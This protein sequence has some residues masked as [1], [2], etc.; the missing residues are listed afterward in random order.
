MTLFIEKMKSIYDFIIIDSP[1][2]I[3]VTD[4]EILF[5]IADG[6]ILV[7]KAGKTPP[8]AFYRTCEKLMHID[9]HN[10]LGVVFNNFS[11]KS[12]YGYYYN[13]YYY[14]TRPDE[15]V[16]TNGVSHTNKINDK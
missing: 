2:F 6:T 3:S 15:K 5:R 14:Y 7:L 16:N 10:F 12:A 8:D 9:Q 1:P 13:Y 11:Y 4:A